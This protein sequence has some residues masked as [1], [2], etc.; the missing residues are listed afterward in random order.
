[1]SLSDICQSLHLVRV[2]D[3]SIMGDCRH[4]EALWFANLA[5]NLLWWAYVKAAW[6]S[7]MARVF[8]CCSQITFKATAK[9]KGKLAVTAFGD[10][11]LHG[12]AFIV[13]AVTIGIAIW[14]LLD[15]AAVLSPLLISVLWAAY[16]AIPS[17]LLLLYAIFGPGLVMQYFCKYALPSLP[18]PLFDLPPASCS[19]RLI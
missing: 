19:S 12:T 2:S 6:R 18:G 17:F 16:A 14:Q 13:L 9:G 1:M 4:T 5:N 3:P 11:W 7:L 15:G 8:F 10:L